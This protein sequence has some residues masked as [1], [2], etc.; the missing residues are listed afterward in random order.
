MN[1]FITLVLSAGLLVSCSDIKESE[2]TKTNT[3]R[4]TTTEMK[5]DN[6]NEKKTT[7]EIK[8]DLWEIPDVDISH[9]NP[10]NR[11][12]CFTFDDGPKTETS[13]K[14]LKVFENFNKNNPVFLR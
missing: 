3:D 2:K 13:F 5:T 8:K 14:L 7:E 11:L 4:E 10:N 12:I 1:K 6:K 9:I